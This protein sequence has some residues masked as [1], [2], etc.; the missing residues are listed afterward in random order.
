MEPEE[1]GALSAGWTTL[2]VCADWPLFTEPWDGPATVVTIEDVVTALTT[3][4]EDATQTV[5]IVGTE[6]TTVL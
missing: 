2:G 1:G 3:G 5:G 6:V 4:V